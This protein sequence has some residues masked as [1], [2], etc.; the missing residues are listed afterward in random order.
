[1]GKPA[2]RPAGRSRR[3]RPVIL[4]VDDELDVLLPLAK[5]LEQLIPEAKVYPAQSAREAL[6]FLAERPAD[7]VI[8]DYRMPGMSGEE[9]V[10]VLQTMPSPPASILMTAY[11]SEGLAY[12]LS[13]EVATIVT[14]PFDAQLMAEKA[15]G[16]LQAGQAPAAVGG[17][18]G[19]ARPPAA[20]KDESP[21]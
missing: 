21:K 14:K 15:R 19:R 1:L 4:V 9:L 20:P 11:P 5:I 17:G 6:D 10:K 2:G 8:T 3:R 18:P 16:L 12:R 7:L 13:E